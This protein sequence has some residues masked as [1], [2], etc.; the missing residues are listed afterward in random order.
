[1]ARASVTSKTDTNWANF[2][3]WELE[4]SDGRERIQK[5]YKVAL[6]IKWAKNK[7]FFIKCILIFK[8]FFGNP[9]IEI[10]LLSLAFTP[11]DPPFEFQIPRELIKPPIWYP[12]S[13]L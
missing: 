6:V 10:F 3:A 4:R 2:Q 12:M 1:M 5:N 8:P 9:W 7:I 11:L 13:H